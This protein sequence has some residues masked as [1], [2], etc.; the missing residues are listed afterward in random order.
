MNEL[1]AVIS[2][3]QSYLRLKLTD[4]LHLNVKLRHATFIGHMCVIKM[5]SSHNQFTV[6]ISTL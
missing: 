5:S 4:N 3:G 1:S 2:C 6:T